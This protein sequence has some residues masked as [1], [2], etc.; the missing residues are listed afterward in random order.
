MSF[1]K[2]SKEISLLLPS[3]WMRLGRSFSVDSTGHNTGGFNCCRSW[4]GVLFFLNAAE[5][6]ILAKESTQAPTNLEAARRAKH[7]CGA[8]R[9]PAAFSLAVPFHRASRCHHFGPRA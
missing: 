2:L 1:C 4:L 8:L 6:N 5:T 9:N 7:C 3:T